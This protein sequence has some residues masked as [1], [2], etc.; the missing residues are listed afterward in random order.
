MISITLPDGRSFDFHYAVFDYNGTL[1]HDGV[2]AEN[3]KSLLAKL[4][5]QLK[6]TVITADT[7]G[8]AAGQL[9][10]VPNVNLTILERG[11]D[12]RAKAALVETL[13][14]EATVAVGN[15]ANDHL[16]FAAAKL[17]IC[18]LGA[19]GAD[20]ATLLAADVVVRSPEEAIGLLLNS[21]RLIA[22]LRR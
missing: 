4:A 1:A 20:V 21:R 11:Q 9:A 2:M 19:E 6:V 17:S 10:A 3:V 22:T 8:L 18:I 5:E 7:F 15:G 14:A 13:G 16:M 12:G